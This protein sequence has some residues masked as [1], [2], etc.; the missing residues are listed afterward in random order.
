MPADT[1]PIYGAPVCN[2]VLAR[3]YDA[4]R[5]AGRENDFLRRH[6][7]RHVAVR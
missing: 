6:A 2:F 1:Y 3:Y 7:K 5:A 4:E